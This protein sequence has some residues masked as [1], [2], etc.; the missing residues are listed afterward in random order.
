[1]WNKVCW[2]DIYKLQLIGVLD[3]FTNKKMNGLRRIVTILLPFLPEYATNNAHMFYLVLPTME[4][5]EKFIKH[6]KA[7]GILAVFHYLSLHQSDFYRSQS[8]GRVLNQS[9]YFSDCLVRL[10]LF[11]E[12]TEEKQDYIIHT[13]ISTPF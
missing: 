2:I 6:L 13:I 3:I 1:M 7:N 4:H 10:P 12:L 11:F 9:D 8:D 5:R